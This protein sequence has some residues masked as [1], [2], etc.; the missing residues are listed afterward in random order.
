MRLLVKMLL[1]VLTLSCL[2]FTAGCSGSTAAMTEQ[3]TIGLSMPDEEGVYI[4]KIGDGSM[5]LVRLNTDYGFSEYLKKGSVNLEDHIKYLQAHGIDF[6]EKAM[7]LRRPFCTTYSAKNDAGEF[8]FGRNDDLFP[9]DTA[10]MIFTKP[11]DGYASVAMTDGVYFGYENENS[12]I[13][14][15]KKY[16]RAAAYFPADGMN[17]C[18]VTIAHNSVVAQT[19][20]DPGKVSIGSTQ[21]LR[22]VLDYAKDVDKA[23]ELIRKYN[24][25]FEMTEQ[26][27]YMISDAAGK[28]VVVEFI[29][30]KMRVTENGYPWQVNTNFVLSTFK[31]EAE[32]VAACPRYKNVFKALKE[33]D[34]VLTGTDPMELLRKVIQSHTLYSTVYN[35]TSGDIKV[36]MRRNFDT[37]YSFRLEMK[38]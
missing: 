23:V 20:N 17:E 25:Y 21:V 3:K 19:P 29:N 30:G 4:E 26:C 8:I 5:A 33:K 7:N 35:K 15:I 9:D 2:S 10:L 28:S 6:Y 38:K 12:N 1:I 22:L 24:I 37:I 13:E 16:M 31:D 14:E 36:A 11:K 18:G 27:H 32:G 34:G